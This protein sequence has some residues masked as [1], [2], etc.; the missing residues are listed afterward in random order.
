MPRKKIEMILT[1]HKACTE[2]L[3]AVLEGIKENE[4]NWKPASESRSVNEIMCHLMRVD[5]K[6]LSKLGQNPRTNVPE[7]GGADETLDALKKVHKQLHSL[8][9]ELNDDSLLFKKSPVKDAKDNDT[10]NEHA[11]HSCQH[12][13]YHLSQVIYLRRALDR[14]W[15]SPVMEWDKA[16]RIIANYLSPK[17]NVM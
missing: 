8:V 10:I 12:N 1:I 16:T 2:P 15:N 7:N 17:P 11:L 5:N 9:Q 3:Y 4:L 13:L 6:F 14:S